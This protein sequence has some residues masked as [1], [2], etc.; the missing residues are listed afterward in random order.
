MTDELDLFIVFALVCSIFKR[1]Y[2]LKIMPL[3]TEKKNQ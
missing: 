2:L 3:S 1:V